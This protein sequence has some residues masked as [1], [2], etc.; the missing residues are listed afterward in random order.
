[1]DRDQAIEQIMHGTVGTH[2]DHAE[3]GVD[4][5][6]A[7]THTGPTLAPEA[8]GRRTAA[9]AALNSQKGRADA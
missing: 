6:T 4:L 8:L 3:L 7:L 1:M 5:A 2:R 9:Y